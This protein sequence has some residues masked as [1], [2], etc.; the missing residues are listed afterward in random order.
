MVLRVPFEQF[1]STVLRRATG[2]E[3]FVCQ[4][5]GVTLATAA[6]PDKNFLIA[7][8]T[9]L[10]PYEARKALDSAGLDVYD[11]QWSLES[12]GV[13]GLQSKMH[14]AAVAY[15]SANTM[16]GLWVDAFPEEMGQNEALKA[17]YDELL[18]NGEIDGISFEEFLRL[19]EANVVV[20]PLSQLTE[21]ASEKLRRSDCS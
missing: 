15:R 11:G 12:D 8:S 21:Y 16:P 18:E 20:I 5:M 2:K 3:V 13:S 7:S 4:E 19:G 17:M 1:A 9:V 6:N 14:V 10:P